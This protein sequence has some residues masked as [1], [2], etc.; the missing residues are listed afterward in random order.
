MR[1][2]IVDPPAYTPPY[3]RSLCA[4]LAR[5]GADVELVTSRSSHTARSRRPTG[6]EVSRR[7][8]PRAR[9]AA[10]GSRCAARCAP[11]STWPTCC[12]FARRARRR[13]TLVHFQWLSVPGL[14][15]RLL[16]RGRPLVQ[17]PAWPPSRGGMARGRAGCS[18]GCSSAWT[19]SSRSPS[20]G[21]GVL[22]DEAGIEA[23]RVH[24]IP[25]GPLDYLTRLDDEAP[26]PPEL[27]AVEGPVV[28][29]LRPDPPVQGR[30][31]AAR[32]LPR[33]SRVP[34]CGSWV[35]RSGWTWPSWRRR[36]AAA[37]PRS[38]SCPASSPTTRSRRSSA[39]P[40]WWCSRTATPSSPG[41]CTRRS[42]FGKAI[43]MSDVGGFPE[44]AAPRRRPH[45]RRGRRRRPR[46]GARRAA[47][48]PLGARAAGRRRPGRRRGPV[49][50]GGHR[51][52][53]HRPVRGPSAAII[54]GCGRRRSRLLGLAGPARL[55]ARGLPAA[56]RGAERGCVEGG[57]TARASRLS[58]RA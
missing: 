56:A 10:S 19:R 54:D 2:Q 12:A 45:L 48:R 34:S 32:G 1:V 49:L 37:S 7:L 11:P 3:D 14:D 47:L 43:L 21:R 28:A 52:A 30:R 24:V 31:P 46:P 20:T 15:A 16:P 44:V 23:E 22:R 18:A 17:T 55:H 39:A 57:A 53:A 29:V 42:P 41:C 50:L 27:A 38:A 9:P 51:R 33:R 4:A 35:A 26:L 5:A 6:Y 25:H 36:R 8:L 13:P 40:T 58:C